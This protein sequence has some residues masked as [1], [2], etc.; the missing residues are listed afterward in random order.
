MKNASKFSIISSYLYLNTN[1][2]EFL[3]Y[4]DA[5][6]EISPLLRGR[7]QHY[8][9]FSHRRTDRRTPNKRCYEKLTSAYSSDKLKINDIKI[10]KDAFIP[11][12]DSVSSCS[13]I[14]K[15]DAYSSFRWWIRALFGSWLW[16]YG[17]KK[18]VQILLI[19]HNLLQNNTY[20]IE[21]KVLLLAK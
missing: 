18:Y 2:F 9:I 20:V 14:W 17:E 16:T 5:M 15:F 1:R 12:L 21:I 8:K 19:G 6:V 4:K 13:I 3:P 11:C 7:I 10:R